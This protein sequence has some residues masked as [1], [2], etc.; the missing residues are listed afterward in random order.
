MIILLGRPFDKLSSLFGDDNLFTRGWRDCLFYRGVGVE[1]LIG[2]AVPTFM[3]GGVDVVP[4]IKESL[5][6]LDVLV[7]GKS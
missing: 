3:F 7:F 5:G 2:N 6:T 1:G 4:F